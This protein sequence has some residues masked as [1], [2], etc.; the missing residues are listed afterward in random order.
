MSCCAQ[1]THLHFAFIITVALTGPL[2]ATV[3]PQAPPLL[4][5]LS[6]TQSSKLL[7][8]WTS[9]QAGST[10][11]IQHCQS[12]SQLARA[13]SRH[14]ANR[15]LE[16]TS[17]HTVQYALA[18]TQPGTHVQV[19]MHCSILGVSHVACMVCYVCLVHRCTQ[20]SQ[21]SHWLPCSAAGSTCCG[22]AASP[23]EPGG[24]FSSGLCCT[25]WCAAA[26][27]R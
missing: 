10:H 16:C 24:G 15:C 2:Y 7:C 17:Q 14:Q 23:L 9:Q 12:A 3:M 6:M 26:L 8:L 27:G 20:G 19:P 11:P 22:A 13:H 4:L 5:F 21:P 1:S 25:S 18:Q